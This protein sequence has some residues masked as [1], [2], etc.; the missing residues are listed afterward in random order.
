MPGPSKSLPHHSRRSRY[1]IIGQVDRGK[2]A[3][4]PPALA[5]AGSWA[6]SAAARKRMQSNRSVDTLPEVALRKALHA[7]GLRFRK[8]LK[9][10]LPE[11]TVRPDVVFTR[12]RVAV[13]LDGCFWHRCPQ[14]ATS[15]RTNAPY[16]QA[17]FDRNVRRDHQVN[18]ALDGAGWRVVRVWEHEP[19]EAAAVRIATLLRMPSEAAA[20][21]AVLPHSVP[22]SSM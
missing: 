3:P 1:A 7:L 10:E 14:H 11:R 5:S 21:E 19:P 13:F 12:A 2:S 22:C 20:D 17:K 6:S 18:E 4:V 15:P 9:I 8:D 16:W